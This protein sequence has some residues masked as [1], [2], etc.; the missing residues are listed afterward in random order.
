MNTTKCELKNGVEIGG[1]IAKSV[2]MREA[3]TGDMFDAEA[4]A[5]PDRSMAYRGALMA[6]QITKLGDVPG[7]IDFEVIRRLTPEDFAILAD[8]QTELERLGKLESKGSTAG[9][10]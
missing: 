2:E 10:T 7:P 3:T 8:T 5:S 1:V 6:C 4:L 9:T